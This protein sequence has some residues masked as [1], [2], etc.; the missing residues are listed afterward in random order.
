MLTEILCRNSQPRASR[1]LLSDGGSL[2]LVVQVSGVKSWEFR[3]KRDGAVRGI[4]IGTYP[5]VGLKA[6]RLQRDRFKV[7]IADGR[8]PRVQKTLAAAEEQAQL[9]ALRAKQD[10]ERAA[11]LQKAAT[12]IRLI[13]SM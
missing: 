11:K 5:D 7:M 13:R 4:T 6:A 10:A 2:F 1:Y 9:D 3:W 12:L 8:D